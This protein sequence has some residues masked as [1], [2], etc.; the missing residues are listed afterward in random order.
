[1]ISLL[2]RTLLL[3][4][5]SGAL[6][7]LAAV[8]LP[9]RARAQDPVLDFPSPTSSLYVPGGVVAGDADATAVALNPG[10]LGLVEMAS[11]AVLASLLGRRLPL[12]GAGRRRADGLP[13]GRSAG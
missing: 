4:I 3:P 10:Q 7:L 5:L 8:A 13:A 12:R 9:G 1:M 2:R 6:A 11:T